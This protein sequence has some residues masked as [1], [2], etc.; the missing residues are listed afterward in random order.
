MPRWENDP[1]VM[2][3][4]ELRK[5]YLPNVDPDNTIAFA[6]Y[7]Q[8]AT[9]AEILRRC[10]DDLTR[11]NVLKQATT[12]AGFHSPYFLD[13]VNFSYTPDDYTPMKTL[14][15]SHLQR[16]G[17]GHLRQAGDGVGLGL[18][19]PAGDAQHRTRNVHHIPGSRLAS[20]GATALTTLPSTNPSRRLTSVGVPSSDPLPFT[21]LE[22]A[23][24]LPDRF[25]RWFARARLGA[26][27]ASAGA[28]GER[29]ATTARRC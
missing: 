22:T 23:A 5:K 2:A 18:S 26:A 16:Q 8:V 14:Y 3:F 24:L 12:L 27:R 10:G 6:G 11:A 19:S 29:P 1:D 13:G 9:M 15:I 28:A 25:R 20:P 17:L 21:P 7:G 4:E